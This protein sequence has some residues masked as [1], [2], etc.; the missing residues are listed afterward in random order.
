MTS[1]FGNDESVYE[2]VISDWTGSH[3]PHRAGLRELNFLFRRLDPR[4]LQAAAMKIHPEPMPEGDRFTLYRGVGGRCLQRFARGYSWT[5]QLHIAAF[6]AVRGDVMNCG[7][8]AVFTANV[9]RDEVLFYS[10]GRGEREFVVRP[11]NITRLDLSPA[12]IEE[13]AAR[14]RQEVRAHNMRA[15]SPG[16]GR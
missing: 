12:M 9:S 4:K 15:C 10:N 16:K 2:A 5:D 13:L 11:A 8:R 6:F 1:G 3:S 7:R 14:F